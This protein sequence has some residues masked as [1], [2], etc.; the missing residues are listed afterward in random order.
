MT[1]PA[2]FPAWF[3]PH[4]SRE[5]RFVEPDFDLGQIFFT[6]ETARKLAEALDGYANPCCLC[7]PRLAHE[8]QRRGRSVR[9]LDWDPRF[10]SV[11]RFHRFDVLHPQPVGEEFDVVMADTRFFSAPLLA[12]AVRTLIS[13]RSEA[14]LYMTF[15][16]KR[17]AELLS[18]FADFELQPLAFPIRWCNVR[19]AFQG[20]FRLYGRHPLVDP[21]VEPPV[22]AHPGTPTQRG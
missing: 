1:H 13:P 7:T 18:A 8:W 9:L 21:E 4:T 6:A 22:V 5:D 14:G 11:G 15:P 12:R 19:P 20:Q 2:S 3:D 16:V 10:E 17:E